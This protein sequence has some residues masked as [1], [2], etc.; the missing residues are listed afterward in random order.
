MPSH[1][2]ESSPERPSRILAPR[3]AHPRSTST[4][5]K[6]GSQNDL[7]IAATT[8]RF[9]WT[10]QVCQEKCAQTAQVQSWAV[11]TAPC[12]APRCITTSGNTVVK[13][14]P[15]EEGRTDRY[16]VRRDSQR[17]AE[18]SQ[19]KHRTRCRRP[20]TVGRIRN[21]AN[22]RYGPF[23][24]TACCLWQ[25]QNQSGQPRQRCPTPFPPRAL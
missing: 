21:R 6:C 2:Q 11:P 3:G 1:I 8:G 18:M 14:L 9:Y 24:C 17:S 25:G 19:E 16:D 20:R 15:R 22:C 4:Q 5:V 23:F 13:R 10:V 12:C 7:R